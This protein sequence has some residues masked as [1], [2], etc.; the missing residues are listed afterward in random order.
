MQDKDNLME[1]FIYNQAS[2][3]L[4]T[5]HVL[6]QGKVASIVLDC[7]LYR[8]CRKGITLSEKNKTT[9]QN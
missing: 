7:F 1:Q 8:L 6:F 5:W 4:K 2:T 3:K 9:E